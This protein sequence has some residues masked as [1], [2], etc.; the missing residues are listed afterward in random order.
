ME[1]DNLKQRMKVYF[2]M[3]SLNCKEAPELVL[4]KALKGGVTLF[5]YRE[6]GEGCLSSADKKALALQL[7]KICRKNHVP[8]IVNDDLDLMISLNAD[9]LHVGQEDGDIRE[10]RR[11]IPDK[12]LGVSVHNAEEAQTAVQIGADYL[13]VGPIYAT[14]TKLDTRDV[15]GFS[16]VKELRA[17]GITAPIVGI[18]GI[19]EENAFDVVEA[20]ADGVSVITAISHHEDPER[21]AR[22]LLQQVEEA[23]K[24]R[25]V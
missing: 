12:I 8:F 19:K 15:M 18:G 14:S 1:N 16:V 21:A 7:Q 6:K 10:I 3:G 17:K 11:R 22:G 4:E 20:G 5:Q 24:E 9:G 23:Y 13:G 25:L 2:I